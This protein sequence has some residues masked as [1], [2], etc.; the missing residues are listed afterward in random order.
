MIE[1]LTQNIETVQTV[2]GALSVPAFVMVVTSLLKKN[3]EV[4]TPYI[5]VAIGV[6]IGLITTFSFIGFSVMS[7][8][9]GIIFGA[10]T[11]A[12]AVGIKVIADGKP[13]SGGF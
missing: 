11:G 10:I 12:S 8:L 5:A 1:T 2:L 3:L 13:E 6:T 7:A 9:V 4:Y